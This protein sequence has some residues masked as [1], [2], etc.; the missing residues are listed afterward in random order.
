MISLAMYFRA[1]V[2]ATVLLGVVVT[3]LVLLLVGTE[4]AATIVGWGLGVFWTAALVLEVA[5]F[6]A[7]R[8]LPGR[9]VTRSFTRLTIAMLA[10]LLLLHVML[11]SV[12][13]RFP[14]LYALTYLRTSYVEEY[15][16][17]GY[18]HFV[19]IA[20]LFTLQWALLVCSILLIRAMYRTSIPAEG[21][22]RKGIILPFIVMFSFLSSTPA[23]TSSFHIGEALGG[24]V[25]G[26]SYLPRFE[27]VLLNQIEVVSLLVVLCLQLFVMRHWVA[28]STSQR[29]LVVMLITV[30][31]WSLPFVVGLLRYGITGHQ[32]VT[33]KVYYLVSTLVS[34]LVSW[35]I[36]SILKSVREQ[37]T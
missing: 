23:F 26:W 1:H 31:V 15:F 5:V 36:A 20:L 34:P 6:G 16:G 29:I 3:N 35:G 19:A 28:N 14:Y 8:W 24:V 30:V 21:L 7:E 2:W 25:W 33:M 4:Y 13:S 11:A 37:S 9:S 22:W 32:Y 27:G 18:G 12:N 10:V 17:G